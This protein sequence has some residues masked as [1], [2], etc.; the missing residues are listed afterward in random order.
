MLIPFS[1]AVSFWAERTTSS[2]GRLP[3]YALAKS[4][5]RSEL[6]SYR[7]TVTQKSQ[8]EDDLPVYGRQGTRCRRKI[9]D[10]SWDARR[11]Q[12]LLGPTQASGLAGGFDCSSGSSM[13]TVEKPTLRIIRFSG[14]NYKSADSFLL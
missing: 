13:E 12:A 4:F 8:V 9:F 6:T 7:V 2:A 5:E 3:S 11:Y 10:A 14:M 1:M